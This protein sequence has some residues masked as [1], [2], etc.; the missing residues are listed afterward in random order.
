MPRI[1]LVPDC[2]GWLRKMIIKLGRVRWVRRYYV[3]S[4]GYLY[5]FKD[6]EAP[7]SRN[8]IMLDNVRCCVCVCV[9]VCVC[10]ER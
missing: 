3:L 10:G 1:A 6:S 2:E 4:Q 8:A 9:C 5:Y 7:V